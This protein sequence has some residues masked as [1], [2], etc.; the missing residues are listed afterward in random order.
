MGYE[1]KILHLMYTS[2]H[3]LKKE[4]NH[5]ISNYNISEMEAK[6]LFH[7]GD[8]KEK[9][10]DLINFF[11]KH[12]STVTQKTKSL[13]QKGFLV[14]KSSTHDKREK[15]LALTEKGKEFYK[16]VDILK[17][18]YHKEVFKNINTNEQKQLYLLLQKLDIINTE[19]HD[20]H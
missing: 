19:K 13:E 18:K 6:F 4:F 2:V 16:K 11:K 17:K 14:A 9:T 8:E 5:V 20:I 10:C 15:V 7:I 1:E 3:F 12:K